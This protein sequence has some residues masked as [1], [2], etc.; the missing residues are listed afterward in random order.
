MIFKANN[1]R[2]RGLLLAVPFLLFGCGGGG[3]GGSGTPA[4]LANTCPNPTNT[5]TSNVLAVTVDTGP[6]GVT[7]NINLPFVTVTVC[8]PGSTS[9]CQTIDHVLLDTGSYGLRI[10]APALCGPLLNLPQQTGDSGNALAECS[11]FLSGYSWGAVRIA[12]VTLAGETAR[13]VPIQIIADSA[14]GTTPTA[15]SS[16]GSQPINTVAKLGAKGILGVGPFIQDCGTGCTSAGAIRN[17]YFQCPSGATCSPDTVSLAKQVTNPVALLPTDN[18]GVVVAMNAIPDT[19][20]ATATGT[21]ALGI[22]T[23]SNNALGT[24][25]VFDLDGSGNL[26]TTYNGVTLHEAFLDTG[27]NGLFFDDPGITL[28][29]LST[30][31]YCPISTLSLSA[32]V[33]GATNGV[34]ANVP[35]KVA[36]ADSLAGGYTAFNDVGGPINRAGHFDWG[37]PFHYGRKVFTAI[38]GRSTPAGTGPYVAF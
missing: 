16:L 18:N 31:F 6:A 20:A 37:L 2:T 35:F 13:S 4:S 36:N 25:T 34:S 28:C 5:D 22:G 19:G 38:E 1:M 29:S 10:M 17:W 27:S 12:D 14:F 7:P 30:G 32:I 9:N 11:L 15:C 23:Q 24:A 8:V 21:L 26:Q 3:G 33:G